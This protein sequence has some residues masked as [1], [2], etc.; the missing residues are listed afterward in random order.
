MECIV[1]FPNTAME[2][3]HKEPDADNLIV[4]W[5]L[6]CGTACIS[7]ACNEIWHTIED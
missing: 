2:A 7:T 3:I 6:S 1:C 4:Y 5:C